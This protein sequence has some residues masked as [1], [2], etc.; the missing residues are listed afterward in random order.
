M[1]GIHFSHWQKT[2]SRAT[3]S[4]MEGQAE[5]V[6]LSQIVDGS[7]YGATGTIRSPADHQMCLDE[8]HEDTDKGCHNKGY[9]DED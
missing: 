5:T 9:Q 8:K 2:Q 3:E 4:L 7:R 6:H 1:D